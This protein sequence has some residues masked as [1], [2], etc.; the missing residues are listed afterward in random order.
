MCNA[1]AP[2]SPDTGNPARAVSAVIKSHSPGV[3]SA[4]MSR[5]FS[6]LGFV[7]ALWV[8]MELFVNGADWAFGFAMGSGS[9]DASPMMKTERAADAVENSYE[10]AVARV[11]RQLEQ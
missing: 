7:V 6:F 5:I 11:D 8:A 3:D 9:E 2:E 10:A 4:S 1:C